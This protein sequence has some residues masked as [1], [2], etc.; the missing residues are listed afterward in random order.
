MID[1]IHDVGYRA[2]PRPRPRRWAPWPIARTALVVAMRRRSTRLAGAFAG[3]VAFGHAAVISGQVLVSRAADEAGAHEPVLG[4]ASEIARSI[5]GRVHETLSVFLGVQMFVTALVLAI[6]AAP[7]VADDRRTRAFDLYLSRPL[8]LTDYA[9]G[10]LLVAASVP[11]ATIVIPYM[12]LW[13]LAVGLAPG[14]V[15]SNLFELFV[16]GLV[17]AV[18]SATVLASTILG[19]SALGERGRT[20]GVAYLIGLVLTS[21]LADALAESGY[22]WG[23]YLGLQR[24]VRTVADALLQV[25]S[26]GAMVKALLP[27]DTN[28]NALIAATVLVV[29]AAAGLAVLFARLR[30]EAAAG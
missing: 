7:L 11:L 8:S 10:K 14:D 25:T 19:A 5:V 2:L 23:G 17:A 1:R 18:L 13:L 15:A 26:H 30:Q 3:F 29:L 4:A 16:P 27:I 21:A 22:A 20:V 24:N 6:V 12:C 9:I 28:P